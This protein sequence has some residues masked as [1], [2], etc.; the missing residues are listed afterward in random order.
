LLQARVRGYL[1]RKRHLQLL[2][3]SKAV[4]IQV[5]IL[6]FDRKVVGLNLVLPT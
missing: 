5:S 1:A 2:R 4:I 6:L 3:N